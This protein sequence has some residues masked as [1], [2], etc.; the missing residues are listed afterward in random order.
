MDRRTVGIVGFGRFGQFWA[1]VLKSTFKVV[2]T[3]QRNLTQKA[4]EM[5]VEFRETLAEV[6]AAA[7]ALF[8]CVPISQIEQVVRDMRGHVKRGAVVLDTCSVKEHPVQVLQTHLGAL[9]QVE[10][11]ATHPMFGPDSG[12]H[13]LAGLKITLWPISVS[14]ASYSNWRGYFESLGLTVVEISPPE[15][16]RLAAYSQGVTHY[17]G[18]VLNEMSLQPTAIDTKAFTSLLSVMGQT[19]NDTWE[20]FQDLQHYNCYTMGMRLRLEEALN[21][22]Y[23]KLLPDCVSP[24][25]LIIGIQGG[26]GSFNEEACRYYVN[27]HHNDQHDDQHNDTEHEIKYLYTTLNVLAALH[28]GEVDRGVFAIQNARGGVVLETIQGLSR[29]DCDI[30]DTFDIVVSH[31]ILHHPGIEFAAIDTLISHPQALAQCQTNLRLRYPHLKLTSGE[32]DLIDQAHCAQYVAEGR[33]PPTTAVLASK[34]CA[35]LYDL[36][37]HDTDLQD[38]GKHNLTTFVWARRRRRF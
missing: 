24:G 23:E 3:D 16:D 38:L 28:R 7:D 31:C 4:T 5:G 10:L 32:G 22:V 37:I 30:L 18:R 14:A 8:L 21:G 13:G 12:A 27:Q 26:Q 17:I 35:D 6:C 20:L 19:C 34:V 36:T 9:D 29:Y 15:H 1:G 2:A 25:K 33:L 11:I